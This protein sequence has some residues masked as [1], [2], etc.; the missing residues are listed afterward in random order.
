MCCPFCDDRFLHQFKY[1]SFRPL[2][3]SFRPLLST[4]VLFVLF[5]SFGSVRGSL[6]FK[7]VKIKPSDVSLNFV[8]LVFL[9][10]AKEDEFFYL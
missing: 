6:I 4:F 7:K 5:Y 1:S 9:V 2:S 3:V 8:F 10:V